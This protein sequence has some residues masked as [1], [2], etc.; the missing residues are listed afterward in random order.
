MYMEINK[1]DIMAVVGVSSDPEKYGNKV[2]F[3]LIEKGFKVYAVHPD[4]GEVEDHKRYP[5]LFDLP[6]AP[7]LVVS[8]VKPIVTEKIAGECVDL[9]I[10]RLWMQPGSESQAAIELC[11]RNNIEV[12]H[13]ECVMVRTSK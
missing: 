5:T 6:E 11:E 10:K 2:F 9:G 1:N 13:G 3:N 4:G 7:N 12:V 8:V